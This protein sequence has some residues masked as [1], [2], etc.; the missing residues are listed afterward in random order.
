ME[1]SVRLVMYLQNMLTPT[2]AQRRTLIEEGNYMISRDNKECEESL[3]ELMVSE[4]KKC[5]A[6]VV[7]QLDQI[8]HTKKLKQRVMTFIQTDSLSM[9]AAQ[10]YGL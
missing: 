9:A 2:N 8:K 4:G 5:L 3:D 10:L 7:A 6:S 1:D